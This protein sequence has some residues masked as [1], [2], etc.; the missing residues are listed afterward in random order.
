M[1]KYLAYS[2]L[3]AV[4][5][6]NSGAGC[7]SKNSDD[8]Q[9][10]N[11]IK[12]LVGGTWEVTETY[13]VD[14][15]DKIRLKL[16]PLA[17]SYKFLADGKLESCSHGTCGQVGRWSFLLRNKD[18]GRLTMYIENKDIQV[19]YGEK[20]EGEVAISNDKRVFVW[21]IVGNP[22]IGHTDATLMDWHFMRF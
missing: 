8:P 9:P 5:F 21:R 16:K 19:V 12:L 10:D 6:G 4:L 7:G 3:V 18:E 22:V 11:D 20:L 2:L 17:L 15:N 14:P 13:T 1:K